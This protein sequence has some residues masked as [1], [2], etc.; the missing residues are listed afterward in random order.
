[1]YVGSMKRLLLAA[2]VA[3]ALPTL[4]PAKGEPLT[5]RVCGASACRPVASANAWDLVPWYGFGVAAPAPQ[6]FYTLELRAGRRPAGRVVWVPAV[7]LVWTDARVEAAATW[8]RPAAYLRAE[9]QWR[10]RGLR[11]YPPAADWRPPPRS[12]QVTV[13]KACGPGG[14]RGVGRA[15]DAGRRARAQFVR[16]S[17]L[18]TPAG[19]WFR[20]VVRQK[21]L[22]GFVWSLRYAP[23]RRAVLVDRMDAASPFW[24][25][26][27]AAL[28]PALAAATAGIA[29]YRGR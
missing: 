14:C 18:T 20:V 24:V 12:A 8:T 5:G 19:P 26:A 27:P 16:A 25:S 7:G 17:P 15:G 29:P 1:M 21:G 10:T 3:L 4:A 11:P 23:A 9:L 2:A 28:L 6:P 13:V 22:N